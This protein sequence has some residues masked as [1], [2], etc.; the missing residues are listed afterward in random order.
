[1]RGRRERREE[2]ERE[3]SFVSAHN[4]HEI[5]RCDNLLPNLESFVDEHQELLGDLTIRTLACKSHETQPTLV[6]PEGSFR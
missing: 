1:M 4:Q 5:I 2:K 6:K 3:G